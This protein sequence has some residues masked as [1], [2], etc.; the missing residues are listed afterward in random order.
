MASK[1]VVTS[2]DHIVLTVRD[3]PKTISFYVGLLGMEH[4]VFTSPSEQGVER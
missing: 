1:C 3:I 4:E 2:L